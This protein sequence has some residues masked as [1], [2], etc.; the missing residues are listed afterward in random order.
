MIVLK[1]SRV[2]VVETELIDIEQLQTLPLQRR[3]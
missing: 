1:N 3:V 2:H